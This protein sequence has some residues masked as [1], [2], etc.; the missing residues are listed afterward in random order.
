MSRHWSK[1][2][3]TKVNSSITFDGAKEMDSGSCEEVG[4]ISVE[5]QFSQLDRGAI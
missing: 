5:R 1:A 4:R 2:S 3:G